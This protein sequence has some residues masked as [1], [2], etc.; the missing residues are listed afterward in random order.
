M[1][2]DRYEPDRLPENGGLSPRF[3]ARMR[4]PPPP[5]STPGSSDSFERQFLRVLHKVYQTIEKNEIRLADQDRRDQIKLEWQQVGG[6]GWGT[7]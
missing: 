5:P 1:G 7:L 6:L 2:R 3:S 4:S